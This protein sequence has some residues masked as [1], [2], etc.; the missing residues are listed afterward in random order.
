LAGA[1]DRPALG[2]GID[3]GVRGLPTLELPLDS[4]PTREVLAIASMNSG[5]DAN[6]ATNRSASSGSVSAITTGSVTPPPAPAPGHVPA[7]GRG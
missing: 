5:R 4:T 7:D 1:A 3:A 6:A 2:I